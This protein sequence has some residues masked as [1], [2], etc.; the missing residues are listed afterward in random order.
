MPPR[1][2][3]KGEVTT[4]AVKVGRDQYRQS[5]AI[6]ALR[7]ETVSEILRSR[8][9]E[10]IQDYRGLIGSQEIIDA[11]HISGEET[12]TDDDFYNLFNIRRLEHSIAQMAKGKVVTKT[13]EELEQMADE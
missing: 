8:L 6:A 3:I 10:Y 7:G 2:K 9:D 5:T 4:I 1:K 12:P 13:I 11:S